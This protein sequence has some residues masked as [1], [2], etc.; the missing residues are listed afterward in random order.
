MTEEK[1]LIDTSA[2]SR[3]NIKTL[4]LWG[5]KDRLCDISG[6]HILHKEITGS[7]LVIIKNCGHGPMFERPD[8]TVQHY[9][10]FLTGI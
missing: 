7:K 6:A 9:V 1:Y 4:V 5:D 3:N 2:I 8:E 10:D